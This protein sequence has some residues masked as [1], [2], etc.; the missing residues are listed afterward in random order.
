MDEADQARAAEFMASLLQLPE[1][2]PGEVRARRCEDKVQ[3]AERREITKAAAD[4]EGRAQKDQALAKLMA[5]RAAKAQAVASNAAG[6]DDTAKA[7]TD[8]HNEQLSTDEQ[9]PTEDPK[10]KLM[11]E[12]M[13]LAATRKRMAEDA[14]LMALEKKAARAEEVK[15]AARVEEVLKA[16]AKVKAAELVAVEAAAQIKA[17]EDAA[18]DVA[19]QALLEDTLEAP[20]KKSRSQLAEV[21]R[22]ARAKAAAEVVQRVEEQKIAKDA[23]YTQAMQ[24]NNAGHLIT[25]PFSLPDPVPSWLTELVEYLPDNDLGSEWRGCI[26]AFVTLHIDMGCVDMVSRDHNI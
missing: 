24:N 6:T 3:A 13:A 14:V 8:E 26:Q 23:A 10:T 25:N 17:T 12:T 20:K 15:K 2:T 9:V 4:R 19:A 18:A 21:N 7:M 1:L 16:A 5:S 11:Q 22:V